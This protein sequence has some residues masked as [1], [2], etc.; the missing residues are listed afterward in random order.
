L[1]VVYPHHTTIKTTAAREWGGGGAW[2]PRSDENPIKKERRRGER[3]EITGV[4]SR[5]GE[6][7]PRTSEGGKVQI[8][9]CG[10]KMRVLDGV[11]IKRGDGLGQ[12]GMGSDRKVIPRERARG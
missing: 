6:E 10:G 3:R 8:G 2:D 4:R 1:N 5:V 12:G 7:Q 11:V 9:G